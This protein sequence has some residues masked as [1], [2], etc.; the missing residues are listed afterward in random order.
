[1]MNSLTTLLARRTRQPSERQLMEQE[2][3][4]LLAQATSQ[5]ERDEINDMFTRPIAA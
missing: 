5:N 3:S 1:M 2:W 4:R